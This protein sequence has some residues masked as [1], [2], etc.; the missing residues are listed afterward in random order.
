MAITYT[1]PG[2]DVVIQ[3]QQVITQS[4]DTQFLPCFIGKGITSRNRSFSISGIQADT[5]SFP[6]VTLTF[7]LAGYINTDLFNDTMFSLGQLVVTKSSVGSGGSSTVILEQTTDYTIVQDIK[8]SDT[9]STATYVLNILNTNVAAADVVYQLNI[10]ASNTDDDFQPQ[11]LGASDRFL[12][13]GMFGSV[14][15]EENSVQ[16]FNDIAIATQIAFNMGVPA[17]YY[18]E[19]PRDFGSD[20]TASDYTGSIEKCYYFNDI[21][22]IVPLTSDPD[23]AS[24]L[25]TFVAGVSNPLDR[26]ETVGFVTYDTSNISKMTDIDELVG[27]VGGYST[28]LNNKR[29]VNIFGG[30]SVEMTIS[31]VTYDL[32]PYF[33]GAAVSSLD[34]VVGP[35]D[36]LSLRQIS[37]FN[38]V[39]GPR[40]RP[41]DW[42]KL[43]AKGVF[44]ILQNNDGTPAVIRHQ[45][46]TAQT[47]QASDQEYSVV[48]NFDV[49]TKKIR[50]RFRPYAGQFNIQSGYLETLAGTLATTVSEILELK[51][52]KSLTTITPWSV[53]SS[54]QRNLVTIL[55]LDP[56]YPANHLEV[57]LIV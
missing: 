48:K 38:K 39:N 1:A 10:G 57:Y 41:R 29:I 20:P 13:N 33:L 19:V 53:S 42:D 32:P 40:F 3:Q 18:L 7:D 52:A 17:F 46:T 26:R 49:V 51:L 35:V 50:D 31:N 23:V 9:D 56:V 6:Q 16:I 37:V 22:R 11:L 2:V 4:A 25:S 24:Y 36:P 44:I 34:A 54:D 47:S 5:S 43:A 45:L 27:K 55:K 30:S 12:N 14:I 15:L 21:Y 28:S 8:F